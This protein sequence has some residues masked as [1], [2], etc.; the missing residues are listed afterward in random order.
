MRKRDIR[1]LWW[2]WGVL[3]CEGCGQKSIAG[4]L[5]VDGP[6]SKASSV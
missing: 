6:S 4:K 3:C 2:A 5:D 1:Q